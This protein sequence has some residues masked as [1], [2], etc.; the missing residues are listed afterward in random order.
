MK[1][2]K[3]IHTGSVCDVFPVVFQGGREEEEE[4]E[5]ERKEREKREEGVS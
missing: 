5:E 2:H 3:Q 4:R 1:I